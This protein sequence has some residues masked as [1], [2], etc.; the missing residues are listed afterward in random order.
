MRT[1]AQLHVHDRAAS[2]SSS[3]CISARPCMECGR[4][5]SKHTPRAA[6][7]CRF[8]SHSCAHWPQALRQL[9]EQGDCPARWP[10]MPAIQTSCWQVRRS[11]HQKASCAGSG[12]SCC[13]HAPCGWPGWACLSPEGPQGQPAYVLQSQLLYPHITGQGQPAAML[14]ARHARACQQPAVS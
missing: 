1:S 5:E 8:L 9:R 3:I 11:R 7:D 13:A 10:L 12:R 4:A 14:A 2:H 6:Q